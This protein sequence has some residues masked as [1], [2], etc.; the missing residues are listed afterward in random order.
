MGVDLDESLI[1][2]LDGDISN[3]ME[4][5]DGVNDTLIGVDETDIQICQN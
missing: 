1:E 5:S 2:E 3:E 4:E